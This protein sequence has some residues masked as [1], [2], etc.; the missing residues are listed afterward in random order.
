MTIYIYIYIYRNAPIPYIIGIHRNM[1][2]EAWKI[3][4]VG[5]CIVDLDNDLVFFSNE[6]TENTGK[7]YK[8]SEDIPP[9]IDHEKRKLV[10]RL[11]AQV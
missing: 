6:E 4:N 1:E 8:A 3:M 7:G 2:E 9:L 11:N 10:K 5:T